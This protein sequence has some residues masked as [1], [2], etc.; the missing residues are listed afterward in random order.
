[1]SA[2][3]AVGLSGRKEE[4]Q[5]VYRIEASKLKYNLQVA[6]SDKRRR[7]IACVILSA[8]LIINI[9]EEFYCKCE[10]GHKGEIRVLLCKL[11]HLLRN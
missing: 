11:K 6:K 5:Q 4:S 1:M 8:L 3:V 9:F 10:F 2:E 7:L